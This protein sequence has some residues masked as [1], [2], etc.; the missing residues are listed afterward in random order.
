MGSGSSPTAASSQSEQYQDSVT[1][2]DKTAAMA[3]DEQQ[4]GY[5]KPQ[6]DMMY[7]DLK[8]PA[9]NEYDV[10]GENERWPTPEEER[11]MV[12]TPDHV[13][14][15]AFLIIITEF[16]ERFTY[17]GVSGIFQNYI[18]NGYKVPNSN[19]G[20]I[21]GGKHMATGLGNF[22]QFWCYFT[23][24]FGAI[25]ADQWWGKYKTI[26]VFACVYLVGDL[27]LTLTSIPASIRHNGAL[28]GLIIAMIIIG[29]GTG[30]IK[31]NV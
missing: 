17:Y 24:I 21:G 1:P 10:L 20:A 22:F 30:G 15:A 26:L 29:L 6:D 4:Q 2:Y 16:C 28:P 9:M 23:P 18:Q 31:S 11:T 5:Y 7:S 13:P 25:I 19:P 12:R 27:V 3:L 14:R 8:H